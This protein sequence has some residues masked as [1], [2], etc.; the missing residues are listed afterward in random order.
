MEQLDNKSTLH[1]LSEKEVKGFIQFGGH[2]YSPSLNDMQN[3]KYILGIDADS[4]ETLAVK[5][6]VEKAPILIGDSF[7]APTKEQF[8]TWPSP[9]CQW[10]LLMAEVIGV[11][12]AV[13]EQDLEHPHLVRLQFPSANCSWWYTCGSLNKA[14]EP[15]HQILIDGHIFWINSEAAQTI[16]DEAEIYGT[17]N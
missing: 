4:M 8:Q 2:V 10:T 1:P 9:Y 12:G 14:T 7:H 16:A 6:G 13:I 3:I 17:G 11:R 15:Y 5:S